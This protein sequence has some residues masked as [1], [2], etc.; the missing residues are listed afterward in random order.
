MSLQTVRKNAVSMKSLFISLFLHALIIF[1]TLGVSNSFS[2]KNRVM[3]IDFTIKDSE[4]ARNAGEK[5]LADGSSQ[6]KLKPVVKARKPSFENKS[7]ELR[8]Q[9][10][11]I[12]EEIVPM[13]S[14]SMQELQTH[15]I[16]APVQ[17]FNEQGAESQD[18]WIQAIPASSFKEIG[19]STDGYGEGVGIT[20]KNIGMISGGVGG[21][22]DLDTIRR[23]KY[24]KENFAYIRDLIQK[25]AAYPKLAR[26]MGWEG[27]VTVSFL[28]SS[29]G[30]TKD[31]RIKQSSGI[32]ILD[33]SSI[34]AVKKA[35]PFPKPP[36]EAYIIIPISYN[37]H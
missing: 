6:P 36:A 28:I 20:G 23:G 19:N 30:N 10:A 33:Q 31:I 13:E 34:A 4:N 26:Q 8:K 22:S 2:W 25:N 16:Q 35:S 3:I 21:N 11:V 7:Q 29:D 14:I 37:F 9:E 17:A 1:I 15:E 5:S 24:L 32:A 12:K 18:K 27:R